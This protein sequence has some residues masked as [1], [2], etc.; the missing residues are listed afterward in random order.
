MHFHGVYWCFP[1][2]VSAMRGHSRQRRCWRVRLM[3]DNTGATHTVMSDTSQFTQSINFILH[4]HKTVV[5]AVDTSKHAV[6]QCTNMMQIRPRSREAYQD[7]IYEVASSQ[8]GGQACL[9]LH[10]V[11]S[12]R[13]YPP[14]PSPSPW[15]LASACLWPVS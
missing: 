12:T 1:K 14:C 2:D 11:Q 9:C 6:H 7:H 10:W 3:Q 4:D 15:L 8:S 5:Q 13:A